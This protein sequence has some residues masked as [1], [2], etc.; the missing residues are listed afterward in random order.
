LIIDFWD[1]PLLSSKERQRLG[2]I[3]DSLKGDACRRVSGMGLINILLGAHKNAEHGWY[4]PL[5]TTNKLPGKLTEFGKVPP[6][7]NPA[8]GTKL[9]YF[10]NPLLLPDHQFCGDQFSPPKLRVTN[11]GI[12]CITL[13]FDPDSVEQFEET[14]H[15]TGAKGKFGSVEKALRQYSDYRGYSIVFSGSR[16]LHFHFLFDTKHLRAVPFNASPAVRWENR[17]VH[18]G[19]MENAYQ[20]YWYRI[21]EI[22]AECLSPSFGTDKSLKWV[23]QWRRFPWGHRTHEK[24]SKLFQLAKGTIVPQLVISEHLLQR[25]PNGSKPPL[26]PEHFDGSDPKS[27]GQK[28]TKGKAPVPILSASIDGLIEELQALCCCE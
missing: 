5:S 17:L 25:A 18:A 8:Q 7:V 22:F 14:L 11:A 3:Q 12:L 2:A 13:E 20:L 6:S 10:G 19:I 24:T 21:V 9:V 15:W 23:T 4:I 16:S 27:L 1:F 28:H 26:L